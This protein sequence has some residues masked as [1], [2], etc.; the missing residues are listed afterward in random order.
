[1]PFN[2]IFAWRMKKRIHQIDLFRKYPVDVQHELLQQLLSTAVETEFGKKWVFRELRSYEQ[3]RDRVPLSD[4]DTLKPFV[5]R[6]MRGEKDLLWPG[7]T[8]WFAKSSGTTSDRS[9]FIPVTRDSLF[10]CHFKGGKD[11]L[12]LYYEN[13]PN[14]K[15]YNGKHLIVGG[16]AQVNQLGMD[17]Y[18]GD[19]SAIILKNLP[20]WA[21]IRRTPSKET[22]LLSEW[23]E[24]MEKMVRETIEE[25]VYILAG[26]PSWTQVLLS[27]I[28]EYTGK[29]NIKEVWPNLELFLHGGVSFEPYRDA[30]NSLIDAQGMNYFE[31]YNASEG[32][33]GIQDVRGSNELL[34]MLDYGVFYEFIPMEHYQGMDSTVFKT[35]DEVEQGVN[36]AMVISTNGGLWR[37][38]VGDTIQFTST[39]PFRFRVSGRTKSY[40]NAFG[41]ELIVENAESALAN[42][43]R[44]TRARVVDFTVGPKH[45][46]GGESGFHEWFIEFDKEPEELAEF[47]KL[48]DW[49]LRKINSD[50]DAKRTGN[51]V[52]QNLLVHSVP[53]GSFEKWLRSK[54]KLGG[55]HKVPRLMNDRS[56]LDELKPYIK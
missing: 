48:L 19:L 1:M 9:K 30:Y 53:R 3:F 25:D 33:F 54:G 28:L 12:A 45:L 22:A 52:L 17:S 41:E 21:E 27:R 43:C 8:K 39:E 23:E 16:S 42:V 20:W 55:Q 24:K 6:M 34:L 31:T 7:E 2:S 47:D 46:E 32:F 50:Y 37:Y 13:F 35:L 26:V 4:Y 5:D 38:I 15:L 56:L 49:E 10:E 11:L 29:N 18:H 44:V 36:Y 14:C 40:I 51:M